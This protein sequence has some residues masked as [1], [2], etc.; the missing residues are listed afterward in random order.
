MARLTRAQRQAR[1]RTRVL[2]A[3]GEE[4]AEHGFRDAKI[5]R[6]A[7]RVELTRGAVYS[8]F[9]GKRALYFSVLAEAAERTAE[10]ARP[11]PGHTARTALGALAR[12]WV[13]RL[14]VTDAALRI[15]AGLTPEILADESTRQAFSQL[16][17]L[18]AVLLALSL[19][20]L[21]EPPGTGGRRVRVA[22]AVLTTLYGTSQMVGVA[23]GFVDPFTVVRACERLADLDVADAWPPP[24]VAH[25]APALPADEDWSPPEAFDAI[26]RR[27]VSLAE[28]G[29][30][31]VLG[32]HRLEA[33]EEAVRSAPAGTAVTA[34]VVT[35]DPAVRIPL[36]RTAVA[37][38]CGCLRQAFPER[39]WPEL[40]LVYDA[41]GEIAAA[42]G[43]RRVGDT[44]ES[45]V[46]VRA[47]RIV[48][49]SDARG[50]GHAAASF[51]PAP[52]AEAGCR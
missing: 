28:D 31:V 29:T 4:F 42:V 38:L 5:D 43:V 19:E 10:T 3:A 15:G 17:R 27:A 49:R 52:G 8:N 18:D 21:E 37:D 51:A 6:I 16:M 41:S 26:R 20:A 11:D 7:E 24:H 33:V 9:P 40:R 45:A 35:D 30:V 36:A 2:V 1:N 13:S 34:V 39:A 48:A 25:T 14:P 44:T 47:G 46:R 32:T 23:P 12:A 22:E 50:A